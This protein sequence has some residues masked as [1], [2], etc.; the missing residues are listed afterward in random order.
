MDY[1][2][3]REKLGLVFSDK[4]KQNIFISRIQ[5]YLRSHSNIQFTEKEEQKF[6]YN[7]GV[8]CLLAYESFSLNL[9]GPT[10]FQRVWLY[11]EQKKGNFTDFFASLVVF[12]NTYEGREDDRKDLFSHITN[13]LKDSHIQYDLL[14]D[15]D[16]VFIFQK[17][18]KEMDA[19]LVSQPLE[20]LQTYSSAHAAF[21]EALKE[22]SDAN[23]KNASNIADR[24]RK[25]LE[26]FFQEF[27]CSSKSLEN[28]KSDYG[29]YLKD[30]GV[31]P[32]ISNNFESLLISY[33]TYM[34]NHAK[35]HDDTETEVLE[36]IMYQTGNIIRLLITLKNKESTNAD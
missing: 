15:N 29:K 6:C 13:A 14:K 35:H 23:K 22:Y 7:I 28:Y 2:D 16:D 27:F 17:G 9:E 32:E 3:Y 33:T 12:Y 24:F 19:A 4:E 21:V 30:R 31:P 25:A 26:T 20:W 5:V 36:Y 1:I 11:L 8:N 10:G 34:N 18:A